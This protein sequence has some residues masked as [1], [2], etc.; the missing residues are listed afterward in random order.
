LRYDGLGYGA[1]ED[2]GEELTLRQSGT[3][4]GLNTSANRILGCPASAREFAVTPDEVHEWPRGR[5]T[6]PLGGDAR[7]P[8]TRRLKSDTL[9]GEPGTAVRRP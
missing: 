8:A 4:R 7:E 2:D 9:Q 5:S 6:M 1:S 3:C